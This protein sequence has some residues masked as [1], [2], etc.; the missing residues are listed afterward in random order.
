MFVYQ[1]VE[2]SPQQKSRVAILS[3]VVV[4]PSDPYVDPYKPDP[5]V[6]LALQIVCAFVLMAFICG[7]V[8]IFH[9]RYGKS[10][11]K[12]GVC[13]L[14]SDVDL[15]YHIVHLKLGLARFVS[16]ATSGGPDQP[17]HLDLH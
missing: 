17:T 7:F 5:N 4:A 12:V 14:N 15:T 13:Q 16:C 11:I 1:A 10:K 2:D 6:K 9:H 8:V 3:I